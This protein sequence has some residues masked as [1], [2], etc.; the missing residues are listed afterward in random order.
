MVLIH[1]A[2]MFSCYIIGILHPGLV[3]PF[4]SDV[5][6]YIDIIHTIL[7]AGLLIGFLIKFHIRLFEIEKE[8]AEA[9]SRAK[10]EFLAKVSHEIRTPLNAI[11][12]F[13]GLELDKKLPADSK[14]NLEKMYNSSIVLLSIINDLLDISKI[15]SGKFE[16]IPEEYE[17]ASF[18][19]DTANINMVRIG[20]KPVDFKLEIDEN[21]PQKMI[22]DE[23]RVRQIL[24]NLLSNAI[25]YTKKGT[26]ALRINAE[27]KDGGP[28]KAEKGKEFILVCSVE[29]TGTGIPEEDMGRIFKLYEQA[30]RTANHAI[31][32]TGLGL[33]ICKNMTELMG[34][35]ISVQSTYGKGSKFTV[36]IPQTIDDPTPI[37]R[38]MSENLSSFHFS[39]EKRERRR[40]IRNPLPYGRVLVVDDVATNLD[41]A[42]GMML[43]YGLTIDCVDSGKEAIRLIREQNPV[44]NLIFM[45]H[46]M[47]EMDGIEAVRIIRNELRS[48]YARQ[49]PIIALTANAIIGTDKMFLDNGFQDYLTK[50]IDTSKLDVVLNKWVRNRELEKSE[51]WAALIDW[52]KSE[53]YSPPETTGTGTAGVHAAP[54]TPQIPEIPGIDYADGVK[55]MGN[56][57][58]IFRKILA[59]YAA[60]MPALL[61][62]IRN[63]NTAD[64]ESYRITIHGIK[65]S[66]RGISANEIGEMAEALEMAAKNKDIEMI[67]TRNSEFIV[68]TEKLIA[69]ITAFLEK[70]DGQ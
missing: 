24:S 15:E 48:D 45:D 31:E 62:S 53:E 54:D 9:A 14:N 22:G 70:P 36:R 27:M 64:I 23:L 19:N 12:G 63:F 58:N 43:P 32:G 4:T 34:G 3:I 51:K 60:G 33:S 28:F 21:L 1:I 13:G 16:F 39:A 69:D 10:A 59:S 6:M 20:S 50:P 57:E 67:T 40:N 26:V 35:T 41:V 49:I 66:S 8:K 37:G 17:T 7:I 47:P 30:D 61:E 56:K 25:K 42:K 18:I 11:I 29:D 46:M 65:G 44:Y 2:V 38:D 52:M 55:R 68:Q 5:P